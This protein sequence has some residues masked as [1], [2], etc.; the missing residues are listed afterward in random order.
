MY[1]DL[2]GGEDDFIVRNLIIGF[3]FCL[4]NAGSL[5][6]ACGPDKIMSTC[7]NCWVV[8]ISIV[9]FTTMHV[10]DMKDQSGD[11]ARSRRSAP[12][13]LGDY[14]ARWTIAAP[15]I[16]WSVTCPLFLDLGPLGY[17]IP[18]GLGSI[19]AGRIFG[20]RSVQ[21]DRKTWQIWTAWT[22]VLYLLPLIRS[23]GVFLRLMYL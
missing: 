7:G 8:L 14:A 18:C 11:Q 4:Y 19:I 17:L 23:P 12:L 13:V 9:I 2:G 22:G 10:Q 6:I 20:L 16:L 5:N 21:E 1:N 3:A 15:V